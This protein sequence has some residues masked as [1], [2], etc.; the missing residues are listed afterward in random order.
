MFLSCGLVNYASNSSEITG[1]WDFASHSTE[2]CIVHCT[3]QI[4]KLI[5]D[6][7]DRLSDVLINVGTCIKYSMVS[8]NI[9]RSDVGPTLIATTAIILEPM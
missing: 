8:V 1:I 6:R 5:L 2:A 9:V 4:I 7:L 3:Y